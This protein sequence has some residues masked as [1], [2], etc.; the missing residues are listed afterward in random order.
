M[1]QVSLFEMA[2][3]HGI[4]VSHMGQYLRRQVHTYDII[5]DPDRGRVYRV[6]NSV[7]SDK[8]IFEYQIPERENH[9][10]QSMWAYQVKEA[11]DKGWKEALKPPYTT[12]AKPEDPTVPEPIVP[13]VLD[14]PRAKK[15]LPE[16]PPLSSPAT[17]VGEA[18]DA[19]EAE[20]PKAPAK[21]K[22]KGSKA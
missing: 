19:F 16:L 12:P 15:P 7:V 20:E 21:K 13:I 22:A 11:L 9:E 6:F 4:I 3:Q 8:P 18:L 1:A 10:T 5:V 14:P 2:S 17:T